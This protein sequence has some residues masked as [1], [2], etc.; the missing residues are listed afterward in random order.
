MGW[1][2]GGLSCVPRFDTYVL[3]TTITVR[4]PALR[5]ALVLINCK[6]RLKSDLVRL[7]RPA[8]LLTILRDLQLKT[9][10]DQEEKMNTKSVVDRLFT[11]CVLTNLFSARWKDSSRS[12][13]A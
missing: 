7:G 6:L 2:T 9:S 11:V 10:K 1:E 5:R 13:H 3:E 8:Q 4:N 12:C